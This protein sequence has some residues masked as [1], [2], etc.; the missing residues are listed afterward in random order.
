MLTIEEMPYDEE[1]KKR[2]D[3]YQANIDWVNAHGASL[4]EKY[5]GKYIAVS[6]GVVY[7]GTT[8]G[9]AQRLARA[10]HPD[11]EPYIEYVPVEKMIRIYAC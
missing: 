8:Y 9:E 10:E 4:F 6:K 11:D 3:R 5:R 7:A 1:V 2:F